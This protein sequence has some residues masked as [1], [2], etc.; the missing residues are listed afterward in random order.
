[1]K[2]LFAGIVLGTVAAVLAACAPT[3]TQNTETA[4]SAVQ[5][6]VPMTTG[7]ASDKVPDPNVAPVAV[8]SVYHGSDVEDGVFQ[9]MDALDTEE[10]DP[11]G[12]IDKL[13]EYGVLTE[14]T[15]VL[16]FTVTGEEGSGEAVL[17]LNQLVSGEDCS[18][19]KL[20]I[21][22][23]NT[24]IDNYQLQSLK[25]KVNGENFSGKEIQQGDDDVL[26]YESD[27]EGLS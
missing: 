22:V 20:L 15:Q 12:L 25:I 1:M 4:A 27:L 26:E 5:E 13:T 7:G 17:D 2:K 8:I 6:T 18:D 23:G 14:G 21:E 11:Q 24:F 16:D 3:T 19:Q 10:L 9:D